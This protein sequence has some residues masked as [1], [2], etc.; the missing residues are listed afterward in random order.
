[1]KDKLVLLGHYVFNLG[2]SGGPFRKRV[3]KQ[4]RAAGR[5]KAKGGVMWWQHW[6]SRSYKKEAIRCLVVHHFTK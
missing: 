5:S 2:E 6:Q 3:V 4:D 1:M